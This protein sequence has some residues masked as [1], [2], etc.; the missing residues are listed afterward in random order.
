MNM[1]VV[2]KVI[3]KVIGQPIEPQI[4]V[5]QTC[6]IYKSLTHTAYI[7]LLREVSN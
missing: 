6:S 2:G 4:R 3:G 5:S 7:Y 1:E